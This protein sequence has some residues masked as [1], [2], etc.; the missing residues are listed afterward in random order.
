[1]SNAGQIQYVPHAHIDKSKWD[2][3]IGQAANGLIYAYSVYLDA[4]SATWDALILNDY[5]TVMPL[6]WKKKFGIKYLYQ[7]FIT[8]QLGVFGNK[9]DAATVQQFL[10][11]IPA[12]FRYIDISLNEGN[13]L[14]NIN[15]VIIRKNFLLHLGKSYG[16]ITSGYRENTV[17]NIKKSKQLNCY[18]KK[19]VEAEDVIKL[20]IRQMKTHQ[21]EEKENIERLRRLYNSLKTKNQ[22][23]VYGVFDRDELLASAI[24][25]LDN[26]RA[27]YILVGNHPESRSTGASHALIDGFIQDHA[28]QDLL[29]DFEG[30]DIST[31][32]FFY[33]S[34]GATA[35]TYPSLRLNRL[36]FFLKWLKK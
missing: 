21:Q 35:H 1:M 22:T 20:A 11:A 2:R 26:K 24:F 30:S 10:D 32:A 8:A 9:L 28:E 17:R 25:F 7:P 5:E 36:P 23:E 27:Y 34:F 19:E 4:M 14:N 13:T 33:E 15:G 6:T 3:C 29:L 12:P 31:L 16:K 18:V